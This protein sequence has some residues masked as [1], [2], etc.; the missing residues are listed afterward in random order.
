MRADRTIR[1]GGVS[2]FVL[3]GGLLLAACQTATVSLEEAKQIT[4]DFKGASFV[5]PPRTIRDITAILDQQKP[6]DPAEIARKE[7]EAD[8]QP[9]AG[10]SGASLAKFYFKRGM[11]ARHLGRSAQELADLREAARLVAAGANLGTEYRREI[12]HQ[13]AWTEFVLGNHKS[14]IESMRRA[15]RTKESVGAYSGLT[16]MYA[17]SGD[18]EEAEK[19]HQRMLNAIGEGRAGNFGG[20]HRNTTGAKLLEA[21]GKWVEA[22]PFNRRA[23]EAILAN[24]LNK[25]Y[26]DMLPA[27][28]SS[29]AFNLLRQGR[30]VEAEIVARGA[31]LEVLQRSGKYSKTTAQLARRLGDILVEEGRHEEGAALNQAAYDIYQAT[32]APENS[33]ALNIA[34]NRL[35][36][37]LVALGR[38]D[39]ALALFDAVKVAMAENRVLYDR[40]FA[41]DPSWAYALLRAGRMAEAR[42]RLEATHGR[43]LERL[44]PKHAWTAL[45]S[46]L[47]AVALART[48]ERE[49][50]LAAFG[51]AVPV[52]M[53]RSR[54]AEGDEGAHRIYRKYIVESHMALLVDAGDAAAAA[55]AFR[56]AGLIRGGNVQRALSASGAR[57]AAGNPDL[58]DLV[59]REQD[60][61]KQISSLFTLYADAI[62]VPA[63]QQDAAALLALRTRLDQLRG[64]RS[65]LMEEIE[66]RF[67]EYADLIN[68]KPLTIEQARAV[69]APG[70]AI[71]STYVGEERSF[72]WAVPKEGVVGFTAVD[73]GR[74]DLSDMVALLRSAL[75]P[76]AATLGDIPDFDVESGYELYQAL[77]EPIKAQWEKADSLL[78]VAHGPLGYLPFSLLPTRASTL[79]TDAGALFANHR[80][81]AWLARSHAVTMLPSVAALRTLRRLPPG[82]ATRKLFA[83][84]GDPYFSVTQAAQAAAPV[85]AAPVEMAVLTN[86]G[87]RTR[88]LPVRLRAAPATSGLASANLAILPRLPDTADEI[89]GAAVALAADLTASVFLGERANEDTVK[90]MDLSGYKVVAFATHG[91]VPGDLD[92]L[93][94]PALA[95]SAPDVAGVEGDGLLTMEEILGLRL[96]ADWVVLSA[97][98]TGS[99]AG[100]GAEAVSG[101]G[102]AFFY[103]GTRALLV[104]NWPVE[105]TSAKALTT[106]LFRR[107]AADASLTRAQA[108]RQ[109][110]LALID[111]PG[112]V[113]A[114]S[115]KA[116]FSYAHP[117]FWAPFSLIGDGGGGRPGS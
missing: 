11:A 75:E 93:T 117:I 49:R 84:F 52:M 106:D 7:A 55:E 25:G 102:R 48:G 104:S 89:R 17:S 39:E 67:P 97:C 29:L 5:P 54:R 60:A 4:A 108:L 74:E 40:Y 99:G 33:F 28:H 80:E 31:L 27:R 37:S 47:L 35:A 79:S 18:L 76:N 38:F 56:L 83:G 101:L 116:V 105:T 1:A 78:V 14:A 81:V 26:P 87:L 3:V 36:K 24:N 62:G 13:R 114:N 51:A 32:G 98:N 92:G 34:R 109:A 53:S 41:T 94:Q 73:M 68:P 65:A 70:E 107:Q 82:P 45:S 86:R 9:P 46:G 10:E 85:Q 43:H 59:R 42:T 112:Y 113:D 23:I 50:A 6:A 58:A 2:A 95:L 12:H 19:W 64:A 66:G 71:I 16:R 30:L 100:A 77:L 21:Q 44:G 115:G 88:G 91:L 96:D 22:E 8:G 110:M 103:A 72:V 15:A 63:D 111:G 57:A 61:Q 20:Y 69:L 90:T